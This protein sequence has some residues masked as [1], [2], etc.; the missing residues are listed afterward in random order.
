ML[1]GSVGGVFVGAGLLTLG[2]VVAI[3]FSVEVA[4]L[5]FVAGAVGAVLLTRRPQ[6]SPC[7]TRSCPMSE[8]AIRLAIRWACCGP[9]LSWLVFVELPGFHS[10]EMCLFVAM[11]LG[12]LVG[13][14][15]G[16]VGGAVE[17]WRGC[18]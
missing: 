3:A 15:L 16:A 10:A 6:A 18:A 11:P 8:R 1:W 9:L 14:C 12:A 7:D 13:A 2:I 4:L 5:L 17:G